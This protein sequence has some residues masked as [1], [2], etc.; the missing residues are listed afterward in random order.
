MKYQVFVVNDYPFYSWGDEQKRWL[1]GYCEASA[2]YYGEKLKCEVSTK[3]TVP[4]SVYPTKLISRGV[5]EKSTLRVVAETAKANGYNGFLMITRHRAYYMYLD[6]LN[7]IPNPTMYNRPGNSYPPEGWAHIL[8]NP[9]YWDRED[10]F[11]KYLIVL[12]HELLHLILYD[13]G[14]NPPT[15]VID[16]PPYS[17]LPDKQFNTVFV[18]KYPVQACPEVDG[19][20][21]K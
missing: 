20:E 11:Y 9:P 15:E 1:S 2:K 12:S 5:V 10:M 21:K 8:F 6:P 17:N 4:E 3:V 13:R 14:N 16:H 19:G 18:D 7:L